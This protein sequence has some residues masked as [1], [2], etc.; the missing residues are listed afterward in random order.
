MTRLP[1]LLAILI[2][3]GCAAPGAAAAHT[4]SGH[5]YGHLLE[6]FAETPIA[7]N[8]LGTGDPCAEYGAYVTPVPLPGGPSVTCTV[9]RDT[10]VFINVWGSFCTSVTNPPHRTPRELRACA[11]GENTGITTTWATLDGRPVRVSET[12]TPFVVADLPAD[13]ILGVPAQRTGAAGH[14]WTAL[15]GRLSPGAHRIVQHVEGTY[16]GSPLDLT[17][18][19]RIIVR[20]H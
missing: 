13:N 4:G 8:P 15:L 17:L 1:R 20:G 7:Q 19:S 2:A 12:V 3:I 14:G 18:E 6:F 16:G 9:S 10:R 5:V 11:Q